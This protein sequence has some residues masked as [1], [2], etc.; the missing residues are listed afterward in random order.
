MSV[1]EAAS[2]KVATMA[3]GTLRITC[4][5]EPGNA[6]AAFALFGA[7]GTPMALAALK[8]GHAAVTEPAAEKPK[9]GALAKLAGMW[10]ADPVFQDWLAEQEWAAT[11]PYGKTP[12][13]TA[14]NGIRAICGIE[15]RV[16]LDNNP[17]AEERFQR[18]IRGPYMKHLMVAA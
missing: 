7:P 10:C 13:E 2:V 11:W 15:S 9:G 17:A 14:A 3:D 18:L 8:V 12:T 6:Q 5:I 1:I 4:D 16:E